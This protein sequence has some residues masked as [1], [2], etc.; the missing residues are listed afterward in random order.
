VSEDLSIPRPTYRIPRHSRGMDPATKRLA[1]I[2][3][4][5]GGA[6]LAIIGGWT[7]MGHRSTAVPVIQADS[8]PIRVKP[9][10]PGGMQ[11][12][13]SNEDLP[14]GAD[15]NGGKLAPPP[16]APAPQALLAP[17]PPPP[18]AVAAPA[19]APVTA[20]PAPAAAKAAVPAASPAVS[21]ADKRT[22]APAAERAAP[23][24]KGALVQLAAVT[25]EDAARSE[26]QRLEKRMPDLFG[27]RQPAFS[28]TERSGHTLWRLRTGGFSDVAQATAFGER[29]HAKGASCSIADF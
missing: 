27:H 10:N 12:A 16:E 4:G 17:P 9:E 25:S 7:V 21:P 8:R 6:L 26:W 3:G 24:G 5:L 28:K 20:P 14:G 23:A 19:T 15:T 29:V 1:L 13:G 18:A 22:V 2:S 11:F